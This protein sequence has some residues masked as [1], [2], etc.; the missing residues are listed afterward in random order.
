MKEQTRLKNISLV[1]IESYTEEE[2]LKFIEFHNKKIKR[3]VSK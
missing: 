2:L 3:I 1:L